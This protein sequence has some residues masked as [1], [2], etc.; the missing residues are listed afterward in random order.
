MPPS[1]SRPGALRGLGYTLSG[2]TLEVCGYAV[3]CCV[4][5]PRLLWLRL[6]G[7]LPRRG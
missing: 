1:R 5:L 4:G 3:Y 6:R 7:R 2:V